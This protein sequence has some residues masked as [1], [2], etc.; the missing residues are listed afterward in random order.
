MTIHEKILR[1][2]L[3]VQTYRVLR[4]HPIDHYIVDFYIASANLIIEIDW[5]HHLQKEIKKY[6]QQRTAFLELYNLEIIRF[7]NQEIT[8]NYNAVCES[9]QNKVKEKNYCIA[10][11]YPPQRGGSKC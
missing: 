6:D 2:F 5:S 11:P 10:P 4:Q 7:M 9:I 1:Q 8:K 3:R